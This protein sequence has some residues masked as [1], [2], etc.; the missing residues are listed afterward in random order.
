MLRRLQGHRHAGLQAAQRDAPV[1]S[2]LEQVGHRPQQVASRE[3]EGEGEGE[4]MR[5][6]WCCRLQATVDI[7]MHC[8]L[9]ACSSMQQ[10]LTLLAC[11]NKQQARSATSRQPLAVNIAGYQ[12]AAPSSMRSGVG[13]SRCTW[14]GALHCRD[15]GANQSA[16][17]AVT[18]SLFVECVGLRWLQVVC[19]KNEL[20][21]LPRKPWNQLQWPAGTTVRFP[22]SVCY[23]AKL[24]RL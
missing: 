15:A 16:V 14:D 11:N 4:G 2:P 19:A 12:H 3:G 22:L 20:V 13:G 1:C 17:N 24:T 5:K 23:A 7:S 18:A 6:V 21:L 10:A 8:S 9:L